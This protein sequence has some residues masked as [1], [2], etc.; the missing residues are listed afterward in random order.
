MLHRMF[1]S[2]FAERN[3]KEIQLKKGKADD[4]K[5]FLMAVYPMR[6]RI[7]GNKF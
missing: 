1:T 4:F 6:Q 5:Q 2:D 7:T 3:M